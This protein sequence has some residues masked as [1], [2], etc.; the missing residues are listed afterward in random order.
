MSDTQ[1]YISP[2]G[3][4]EAEAELAALRDVERPKIIAA[5]KAAREEG[6]LSENAE[7]HAA[8]EEQGLIEARITTLEHLLASAEV[9]EPET[10]DVIGV[11]SHVRL[12]D[13]DDEKQLTLVHRLEADPAERK[14]SSESPIARALF[15][16]RKGE[17]VTVETPSGRKELEILEVS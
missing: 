13:G 10:G 12:R 11:G 4:A 6:D 7:Y 14:I 5:I 16:A 1:N 8:R 17:R 9:R 15:G 3:R 2:E